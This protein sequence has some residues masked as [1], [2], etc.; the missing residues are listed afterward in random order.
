MTSTGVDKE[1]NSQAS[2]EGRSLKPQQ[3]AFVMDL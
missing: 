1:S 3:A 2:L